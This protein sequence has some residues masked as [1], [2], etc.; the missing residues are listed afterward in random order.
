MSACAPMRSS[1]PRVRC[2]GCRRILKGTPAVYGARECECEPRGLLCINC[3]LILE[4]LDEPDI[5]TSRY[6]RE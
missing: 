5:A 3:V 1:M 4:A 2:L 6:L